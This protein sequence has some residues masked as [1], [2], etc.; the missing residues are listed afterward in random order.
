VTANDFDIDG[1]NVS[2][3]SHTHD[4]DK[5]ITGKPSLGNYV[6]SGDTVSALDINNLRVG[7]TTIRKSGGYLT[8]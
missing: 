7:G 5:D 3:K 8:Y 6:K 4:Y 2:L 1:S